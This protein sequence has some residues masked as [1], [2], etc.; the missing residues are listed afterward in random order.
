MLEREARPTG[1]IY[2]QAGS[3]HSAIPS[4]YSSARAHSEL[5]PARRSSGAT[6]SYPEHPP[7][8][9][10]ED[11][12]MMYHGT[13]RMIT[14]VSTLNKDYFEGANTCIVCSDISSSMLTT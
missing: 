13:N 12:C 14:Q 9:I 5:Q 1:S 10:N 8:Q 3:R 2:L 11:K 4:K 7:S 6:G